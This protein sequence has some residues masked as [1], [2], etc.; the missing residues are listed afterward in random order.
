MLL[1]EQAMQIGGALSYIFKS[2]PIRNR[3]PKFEK[4]QMGA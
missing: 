3:L 2:T 1:Q 4:V